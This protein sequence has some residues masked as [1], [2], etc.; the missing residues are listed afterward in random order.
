MFMTCNKLIGEKLSATLLKAKSLSELWKHAQ[1]R[2]KKHYT[3][4]ELLMIMR[5]MTGGTMIIV[6]VTCRIY[7]V[8]TS[9]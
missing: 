6:F 5:A 8:V 3:V 1:A 9:S 4:C 7:C 2:S